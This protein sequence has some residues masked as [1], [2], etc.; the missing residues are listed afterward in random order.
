MRALTVQPGQAGTAR[1]V[2]MEPTTVV[3]KARE[4]VERIGARA[5]YEPHRVLV[6]FDAIAN[7]A[8]YGITC[9]T[10]VSTPGRMST[11]D[12][13]AE[14]LAR[15]DLDWLQRL[16]TRRVVLEQFAD[17]LTARDDDIKVVIDL[18]ESHR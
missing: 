1:L 4:Q 11:I 17:A 14:T 15:A 18:A 12:A 5:W 3:T 10:G 13:G 7:T 16:I 2:L 6:T 8:S 9:L